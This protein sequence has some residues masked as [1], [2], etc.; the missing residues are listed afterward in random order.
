MTGMTPRAPVSTVGFTVWSTKVYKKHVASKGS[1]WLMLAG[2][3][4]RTK[5]TSCWFLNNPCLHLSHST[6][7]DPVTMPSLQALPELQI[8]CMFWTTAAGWSTGTQVSSQAAQT[9]K[10]TQEQHRLLLLVLVLATKKKNF[11]LF[12]RLGWLFYAA[13]FRLHA[14]HSFQKTSAFLASCLLTSQW[15]AGG[16]FLDCCLCVDENG[17]TSTQ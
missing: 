5:H 4:T 7:K 16:V 17:S 6:N 8:S 15:L 13:V 10:L 9:L 14:H 11:K 1:C 2:S 3:R 12:A